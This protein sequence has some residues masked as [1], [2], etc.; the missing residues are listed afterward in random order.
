MPRRSPILREDELIL[1]SRRGLEAFA[2]QYIVER[3]LAAQSS[4]KAASRLVR[5]SIGFGSAWVISGRW[6]LIVLG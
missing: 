6:T 1:Y 5:F 3:V 2:D 4:W